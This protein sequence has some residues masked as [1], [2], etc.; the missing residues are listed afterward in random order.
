[1]IKS[2]PDEGSEKMTE[3][4]PIRPTEKRDGKNQLL[5]ADVQT[6]IPGRS[7]RRNVANVAKEAD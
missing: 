6:T 5:E 7:A 4:S 3:E 1:L 2:P